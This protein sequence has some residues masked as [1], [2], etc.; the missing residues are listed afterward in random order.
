MFFFF[1]FWEVGEK[2]R[3]TAAEPELELAAPCLHVSF[4]SVHLFSTV[5]TT[6]C[7]TQQSE[8]T[9]EQTT[10]RSRT[11]GSQPVLALPAALLS[12]WH[13]FV[14]KLPCAA[15]VL[16]DGYARSLPSVTLLQ[17]LFTR[18]KA[19]EGQ[20]QA[21]QEWNTLEKVTPAPVAWAA[22]EQDAKQSDL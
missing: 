15:T 1:I 8:G 16:R 21:E 6:R 2:W 5:G 14:R 7:N 10:Q 4:A 3:D 12:S 13:L 22:F 19:K 11:P 18:H 9:A 17:R 20:S